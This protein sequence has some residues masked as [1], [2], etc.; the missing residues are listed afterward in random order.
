[1]IFLDATPDPN[2]ID[3]IIS[4]LESY[5]SVP[6]ILSTN[7]VTYGAIKFGEYLNKEKVFSVIERRII[8]GCTTIALL[9]IF[10][11]FKV[12]NLEILFL[13]GVLSPFTYSLVLKKIFS[14][15]N[16]SIYRN[17]PTNGSLGTS[18]TSSNV[19]EQEDTSISL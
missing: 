16:I 9:G 8:A 19:V 14:A 4:T 1:M 11:F 17:E 5:I 12:S 2:F 18:N 3:T 7:I 15:L 10:Y 6:F 13:S